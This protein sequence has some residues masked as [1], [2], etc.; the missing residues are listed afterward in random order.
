MLKQDPIIWLNNG[1][2][3]Q[4]LLTLGLVSTTADGFKA[5]SLDQARKVLDQKWDNY[6]TY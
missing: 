1:G 2:A 3:L 4:K 5:V 6:F